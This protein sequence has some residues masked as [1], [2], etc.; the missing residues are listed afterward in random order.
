MITDIRQLDLTKLYTYADYLTWRFPERVELIFGKVFAMSPAPRWNHQFVNTR[1][2]TRIDTH[3][4]Q[5][6]CAVLTAPADLVLK[7]QNGIKNIV[8]QP[9]LMVICD[10]RKLKDEESN[11]PPDLVVEVLSKSTKRRDRGD[12]YRLYE[13][14]GVREYW[15]IDPMNKEA[16]VY[17]AGDSR[18]FEL[19][20]RACAGETI[21]SRLFPSLA[22]E[23]DDL[24]RWELLEPQAPYG[25]RE[26]LAYARMHRDAVRI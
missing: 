6:T 20:A 13:S 2:N 18:K 8:L 23:M 12:K 11:V 5:S 15:I 4:E 14:F 1:L 3:F 16:E 25:F 17:F 26:M 21:K 24:F 19:V 9:D 7:D 22:I 10:R